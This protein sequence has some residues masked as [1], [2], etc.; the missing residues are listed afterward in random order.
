VEDNSA[1]E[2]SLLQAQ[3]DVLIMAHPEI[4]HLDDSRRNRKSGFHSKTSVR[5]GDLA[6]ITSA[7][8]FNSH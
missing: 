8:L 7:V 5:L 3:D 2:Q 4:I 1:S 6:E